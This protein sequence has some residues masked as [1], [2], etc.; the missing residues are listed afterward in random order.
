[1]G[2]MRRDTDPLKSLFPRQLRQ[3]QGLGKC[4]L[5]IDFFPLSFE[6]PHHVVL[7]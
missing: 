7:I 2:E 6:I 4:F 1:M 3:P 5:D